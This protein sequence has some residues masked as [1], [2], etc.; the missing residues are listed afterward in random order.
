MDREKQTG[1][2]KTDQNGCMV[3]VLGARTLSN[4]LISY[5]IEAELGFPC[6]CCSR[7]EAVQESLQDGL[8]TIIVLIDTCCQDLESLLYELSVKRNYAILGGYTALINVRKESN[9]E[10]KALDAGIR[11]IFYENDSKEH[12]LKGIRAMVGGELW[13][14][15]EVL[16]KYVMR[17][18]SIATL[19]GNNK[20]R[21]ANTLTDREV[22]VL[23]LITIGATNEDIAE[24]LF[25]SPHTVKTH[26]YNIFKK[27]NVNN[28]FQAA[29]WSA[30]NLSS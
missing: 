26:L 12:F 24:K 22:E 5:F 11:G 3:A 2:A 21:N 1:T 27:I 9:I 25:I 23:A 15:R 16:N 6:T 14:S 29:L 10:E 17:N 18:S 30:K 7:L 20:Q 4:E 28:R 19:N 13:V 8:N